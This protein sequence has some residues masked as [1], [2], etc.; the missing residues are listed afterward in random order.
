MDL[1]AGYRIGLDKL[2][3]QVA[4]SVI[5]VSKMSLI[6]FLR[7]AG[8]PIHMAADLGESSSSFSAVTRRLGASTKLASMI[9][10]P[11]LT[12]PFSAN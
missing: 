5:L 3:N 7:P 2:R 12:S 8:I 4:F 1:R 10:P 11:L 6:A 9:L